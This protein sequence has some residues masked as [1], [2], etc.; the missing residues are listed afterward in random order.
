MELTIEQPT[1]YLTV[2]ANRNLLRHTFTPSVVV[3]VMDTWSALGYIP[4]RI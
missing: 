2:D 3:M 4:N 1:E